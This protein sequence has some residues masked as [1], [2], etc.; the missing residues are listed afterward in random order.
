[1]PIGI[2]YNL[3]LCLNNSNSRLANLD[4]ILVNGTSW[5]S[6][7]NLQQ[8]THFVFINLK[9]ITEYIKWPPFTNKKTIDVLLVFFTYMF[10]FLSLRTSFTKLS[11]AVIE[12]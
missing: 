5:N 8:V 12:V 11:Q 10:L 1:M 7:Y 2:L 4:W 6:Q 9:L 3:T